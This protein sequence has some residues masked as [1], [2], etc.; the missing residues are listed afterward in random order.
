ME[1]PSWGYETDKEDRVLEVYKDT[2]VLPK[3]ISVKQMTVAKLLGT[4]RD[5]LHAEVIEI[6]F[7]YLRLHRQCWRVLGAVKEA[8]RDDFIRI[9]GPNYIE[10]E[11]QL[12]FV[13][14][15]VLMSATSAQQASEVLLPKL[16]GVQVT[17]KVLHEASNVVQVMIESGLGAL[18]VDHILPKALGLQI[19]FEFEEE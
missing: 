19:D 13:V 6:S 9:Y 2:N 7:D 1:Q 10:K 15:Y 18:I 11:S 14:G 5:V 3:N 8:C 17:S 4:L 16:Q 12:P